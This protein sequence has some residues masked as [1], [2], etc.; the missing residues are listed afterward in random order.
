MEW[1]NYHHLLYFWMVAK[2][3]GLAPAAKALRLTHPTLH[4]QI[5]ALEEAFGEKLLEKKGRKLELTEM[6]RLVYGYADEIFGLGREL[7][8]A[9]K[10]RPTGRPARLRVGVVDALPKLI[11]RR[12]LDPALKLDVPVHLSVT[13]DTA[14]RLLAQLALH[15]LDVVLAD[16][17]VN[18]GSG[19]RAYG[20][21]MGECGTTFFAAKALAAK[22]RPGFPG[23]LDRAPMLMPEEGSA[24]R[25][26]MEAW[27]EAKKVRPVVV[28]EF[29]DSALAKTFGQDGYGVFIAPTVIEEQVKR[30]YEVEIVGREPGLTERF[31]A[32]SVERRLK[33]PA[34]VAILEGARGKMFA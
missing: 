7:L 16:A 5:R 22:V 4:A 23:S 29:A 32:I 30:A 27:F 33:H 17:P 8:D 11:V 6:G 12:L 26:A 9:V 1:L 20:H 15:E 19:V 34:V 24:L 2:E 25:R 13:E 21:L 14:E 31:Y 10:G 18:P 3:G 28:A